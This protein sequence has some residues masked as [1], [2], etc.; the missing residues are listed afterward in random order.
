MTIQNTLFELPKLGEITRNKKFNADKEKLVCHPDT[1]PAFTAWG[2]IKKHTLKQSDIPDSIKELHLRAARKIAIITEDAPAQS[3]KKTRKTVYFLNNFATAQ[4]AMQ[5][6]IK[7]LPVYSVLNIDPESISQHAWFEVANLMFE[8]LD[9]RY[10]WVSYR[11]IINQSM[12]Q[13]L[14]Q[15]FFGTDRITVEML[16]QWS[17]MDMRAYERLRAAYRKDH[18]PAVEE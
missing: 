9:H 10:G 17:G 4:R 1:L 3:D 6:D 16:L 12:P 8:A 14:I 7:Q 2:A 15:L 5:L 13:H 18:P 11:D